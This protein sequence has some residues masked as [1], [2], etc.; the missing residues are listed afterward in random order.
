M[1][2]LL[3]A[4]L[5][6]GNCSLPLQL[7][8]SPRGRE[9]LISP[10]YFSIQQHRVEKGP[11]EP[12]WQE[13]PVHLE[14]LAGTYNPSLSVLLLPVPVRERHHDVKRGEKEHEV[15]EGVVVLHAI[16]LVIHDTAH[17][18]FLRSRAAQPRSI[19]QNGIVTPRQ[20]Q[21]VHLAVT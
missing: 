14:T 4:S 3:L 11:P 21:L 5:K 7:G 2:F 12:A 16:L 18:S 15:K 19:L 20:R 8:N 17:V 13:S 1:S 6:D 9:L 10:F